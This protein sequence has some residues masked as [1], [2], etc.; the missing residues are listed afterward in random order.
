LARLL[1]GMTHY[2]S[3]HA[4]RLARLPRTVYFFPSFG[5]VRVSTGEVFTSLERVL[6]C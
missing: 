3:P 6:A 5:R 1:A 2:F 4:A